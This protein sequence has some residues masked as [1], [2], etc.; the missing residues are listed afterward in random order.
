M[1]PWASRALLM[2]QVPKF[3]QTFDAQVSSSL[4]SRTSTVYTRTSGAIANK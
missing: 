4:G 2:F 3:I 1:F